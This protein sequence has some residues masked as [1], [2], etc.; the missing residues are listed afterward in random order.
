M[1]SP[2]LHAKNQLLKDDTPSMILN[3]KEGRVLNMDHSPRII[4]NIDLKLCPVDCTLP[5]KNEE[6]NKATEGMVL[7]KWKRYLIFCLL[8]SI[9]L[10]INMDDGTIPAA[11]TQ[12]EKK[13]HMDSDGI[14][15]FGTLVYVGALVGSFLSLNIINR[16][17]RKW[18]LV[19]YIILCGAGLLSFTKVK[20]IGFLMFNRFCNGIFQ[21]FITIYLPIWIDQFGPRSRKTVMMSL[22]QV[23]SPL[24]FIL[25]YIMT[26]LI[27]SRTEWELSY[28]IQT[29]I[30]GVTAFVII[31]APQRFFS[32]NLLCLNPRIIK[33]N[34][35]KKKESNKNESKQGLSSNIASI[36]K[37]READN[38]FSPERNEEVID[39]NNEIILKNENDKI[40]N[41]TKEPDVIS[42]YDYREIKVEEKPELW[43]HLKRLIRYKV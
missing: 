3:S 4:E 39:N 22:H 13:L 14:G 36:S 34:D 35:N 11:T 15:L 28:Y 12:I 26:S 21:S 33:E 32:K 42:L 2:Q 29:G 25:G 37:V 10:F 1:A 27:S 18:I 17:S 16:L 5:V 8:L 7:P 20:N 38:S 30:M 40:V 19:I 41:K 43:K 31:F 24:G 9:N 6:D 23:S